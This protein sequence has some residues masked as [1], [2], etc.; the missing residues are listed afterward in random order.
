MFSVYWGGSNNIFFVHKGSIASEVDILQV[1]DV[2]KIHDAKWCVSTFTYSIVNKYTLQLPV[3][4]LEVRSWTAIWTPLLA[5][6][7]SRWSILTWQTS[8][9]SSI[10]CFVKKY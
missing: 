10:E 6:V 3:L 1:I 8:L 7:G 2:W 5:A 4:L 9:K